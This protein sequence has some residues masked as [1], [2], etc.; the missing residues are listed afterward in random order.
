RG[1][2]QPPA[3]EAGAGLP[4]SLPVVKTQMFADIAPLRP[5]PPAGG[6]SSA[7]LSVLLS[8]VL[9]AF[10]LDFERESAVSLAIAANAL[11]V[12]TPEGIR[13]RDLPRLTGVSKEALSMEGGSLARQVRAMTRPA[14]A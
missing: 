5:R 7:D 3:T 6:I 4:R 8:Q 9:L 1:R 10:T 13:T 12:L 2:L 11:R 14:P